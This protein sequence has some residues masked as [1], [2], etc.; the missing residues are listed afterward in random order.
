[1]D[2]ATP[3]VDAGADVAVVDAG[4]DAEA[5][6]LTPK[7]AW[8]AQVIYLVIPDRFTNGDPSNDAAG[9]PECTDRTKRESLPRRR[10]RGLRKRI[11]IL[12]ELGATVLW[13][14]PFYKQARIRG[15]SCGYHGYGR[16]LRS[17]RRRDRAEA[18]HHRRGDRARVRSAC[19]GQ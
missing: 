3:T 8:L 9:Y 7:D 17:G 18:R 11:R 15:G 16:T 12:A 1:V 10:H 14:T 5:G 4:V 19:G 13:T 2:A 6:T